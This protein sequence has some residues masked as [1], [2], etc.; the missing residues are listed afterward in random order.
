MRTFKISQLRMYARIVRGI[1]ID[2]TSSRAQ[3]AGQVG[4]SPST[5]GQHVDDLIQRGFVEESGI[6]QGTVGR[7]KRLLRLLPGAGWFAGVEFTSGR[8][9]AAR[10]NFAGECEKVVVHLLPPDMG[11]TDLLN[12]IHRC[13]EELRPGATGP[14]LGIGIG[15]TGFVD[16]G[17]GVVLYAEFTP[18]WSGIPLAERTR[19]RFGV[20]VSVENNLHV[21][22]LAER[23]FGAGR[24]EDNFVIVRARNGFGMGIVKDGSLMPGAHHGAGEIGL[25]PWPLEKG[26]GYVYDAL[27]AQTIWRD[28]SGAP[29]EMAPPADLPAALTALSEQTGAA[30]DHCVEKYARVL[31]MAQ[32]LIDAR[33]FF[34]HGPLR[35][36]GAR[37]CQDITTAAQELLPPL[38][39][40]PLQ[41]VP[42][43]LGK[44]SGALGAAGLAMEAWDP[45]WR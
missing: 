42:S 38:R 10:L 8:M 24:T 3:L 33:I 7:P 39:H 29:P 44:E 13:I 5:M 26:G 30:W 9:Q 18:D 21:I 14:M 12:E 1:R 34:L 32:L 37:F 22:A 20:P 25:W 43:A 4:I 28:L 15:S 6:E 40:A 23:W 19:E 27:S 31:G 35:A 41:L 11:G 45:P 16:P 2:G 36:L 17:S